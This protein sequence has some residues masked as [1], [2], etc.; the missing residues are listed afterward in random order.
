MASERGFVHIVALILSYNNLVDPSAQDEAALRYATINGNTEIVKLLLH[1]PRVYPSAL[2]NKSLINALRKNHID[3]ALLIIQDPRCDLYTGEPMVLAAQNR[4]SEI[5]RMFLARMDPSVQGAKA[6]EKLLENSLNFY[7]CSIYSP[8]HIQNISDFSRIGLISFLISDPRINSQKVIAE[9][10]NPELLLLAVYLDQVEILKIMIQSCMLLSNQYAE[11]ALNYAVDSGKNEVVRLLLQSDSICRK[12]NAKVLQWAVE[13]DS[14][15][16]IERILRISEA[17][18]FEVDAFLVL[19]FALEKSRLLVG[20]LILDDARCPQ[21]VRNLFQHKFDAEA[22]HSGS[23]ESGKL[24]NIFG[25]SNRS[26][27]IA[28]GSDFMF[29]EDDDDNYMNE[30]SGEEESETE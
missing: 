13:N 2:N 22:Q 24:I 11:R 25:F 1:D 30:N 28:D 16:A 4:Q 17:I 8:S 23:C 29:D 3:I 27:Y 14:G 18:N 5:V 19:Q 7:R 26:T 20:Q 9:V 21:V 12:A 15:N 10:E 6:L